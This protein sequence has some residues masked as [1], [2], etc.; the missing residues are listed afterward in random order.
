M[1]IETENGERFMI[2]GQGQPRAF[3][4]SP[5]RPFGALTHRMDRDGL[6]D[7]DGSYSIVLE[8]DKL[9]INGKRMPDEVHQKYLEIFERT[10]GYPVTG[11][12]K[13][14]ITQ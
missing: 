14:E 13:I 7:A 5:G 12:T 8:E 3:A 1:E 11:K 10:Q 6:I 2:A 9:R 4:T